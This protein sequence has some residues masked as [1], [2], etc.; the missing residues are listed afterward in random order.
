[1]TEVTIHRRAVYPCV[2]REHC[3]CCLFFR[4]NCGLSLCVQGTRMVKISKDMV[5]RFIPVCT[6]NTHAWIN[7]VSWIFG[8]SLCVQGTRWRCSGCLSANP[9]YP[10]VYREHFLTLLTVADSSRFIPVCTGNTMPLK[11]KK[12]I[13]AVYPCVYREHFNILFKDTRRVGLSLCVQ[14]TH[15]LQWNLTTIYRFIPVCTGNTQRF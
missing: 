1:M 11:L 6:G 15:P 13:M 5:N 8:L 9:V 14:G 7:C 4:C 12:E 2:Y 10:C 3:V